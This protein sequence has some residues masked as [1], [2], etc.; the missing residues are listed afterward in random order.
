MKIIR[1]I[2][3]G[4]GLTFHVAYALAIGVTLVGGLVF[5]AVWTWLIGRAVWVGGFCM[6]LL[7]GLIVLLVCYAGFFVLAHTVWRKLRFVFLG[8]PFASSRL[9]DS[10]NKSGTVPKLCPQASEGTGVAGAC[11]RRVLA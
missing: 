5:V 1:F 6:E 2:T 7:A 3:Y 9:G 11:L 8:L 4:I 10:V